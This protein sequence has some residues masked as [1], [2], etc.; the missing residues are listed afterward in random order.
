MQRANDERW[1]LD[2]FRW[3]TATVLALMVRGAPAAPPTP[4]V[5]AAGGDTTNIT[6]HLTSLVGGDYE[7]AT[8]ALSQPVTAAA[9]LSVEVTSSSKDAKVAP[10]TPASLKIPLGK[11]GVAFEIVTSPVK[12]PETVVIT[13]CA[14]S[15]SPFPCP[16]VPG[17]GIIVTTTN[18]VLTA[19]G[20]ATVFMNPASVTAGSSSMGTVK[21]KYP[22]PKDT[23]YYANIAPPG[24]PK[25]YAKTLRRGG[26]T[27]TLA[28]SSGVTV[29]Q[30]ITIQSGGS[31]ATFTAATSQ[32]AASAVQPSSCVM[33]PSAV[34]ATI[35]AT[36][37]LSATGT[38]QI[39]PQ[40][41]NTSR[42]TSNTIRIDPSTIVGVS[43]DGG[44]LVLE[45]SQC[46]NMLKVGSVM[47]MEH[48]G[49]LDVKKVATFPPNPN[50][51]QGGIAV[52]VGP[53]S[54]TDFINDGNMQV[55]SQKLGAAAEPGGG[56][57]NDPFADAAEPN[58]KQPPSDTWKYSTSGTPTS[59]MFT[60]FK[61]NNGMSGSVTAKGQIKN[62]G[63]DF[64]V[65]I[66]DDKVQQA[67]FTADMD[68]SVEVDWIAQD[69]SGNNIGD[70]R[71]R[72]RP[73][74]SGLVD[75]PDDVPF[76]YQID[77]NLIFK[78]GFGEKAAARG[79]FKVTFKGEGGIDGSSPVNAGNSLDATPDVS[80]TTSSAKAPH[81][82]V[83]AV[84]V[85]RL[86]LSFGTTS[87]LWATWNRQRAAMS[88]NAAGFADSFEAQLGDNMSE[89]IEY[90]DP[91]DYFKVKRGAWVQWAYSVS[92]AGTGFIAMLQC[93]QYYHL[94]LV[95][96]GI[97][98]DMLGSISGSIPPE[99]GVEAFRKK[100]VTAIPSIKGCFPHK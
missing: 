65:V 32:S 37:E 77:A 40:N 45:H 44:V 31:S 18:L 9:G 93:Q 1:P 57:S 47:F 63:F 55:F 8:V 94:Y 60:A 2:V 96:A 46:S 90:P 21:L 84:N 42:Y 62:N 35:T 11:T 28:S 29:T 20:P 41:N 17:P 52:G 72:M 87:F 98:K 30:S 100:G 64:H 7:T 81:G 67:R 86:A 85:P 54:L 3:L 61:D 51:P 13:A 25:L 4:G 99:D 97:D 22:A 83:V 92:Y 14:P 23:M 27:V 82:V 19:N 58:S 16:N 56:G 48:L 75:G 39:Q 69:T 33:G 95:Q 74:F 6:L 5:G 24:A 53:A 36:W 59:Y 91:Q 50:A 78:P 68:G 26:A 43:H 88:T 76:L 80:S 70:P 12:S 49:V 10:L 79:H 66:H 89:D 73:L 71:L 34:S 38:L 15:P